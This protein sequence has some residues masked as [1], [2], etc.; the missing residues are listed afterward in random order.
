MSGTD[1]QAPP[2]TVEQIA[3]VCHEANRAWCEANGDRSQR[4]WV[5]AEEW[6]RESAM[7]GVK[8]ALDGQGPEELHESWCQ[9]KLRDGWVYGEAKDAEAKTHP[10]LMPYDLLPPEQRAK[11]HLFLAVVRALSAR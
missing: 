2:A 11:D 5:A 6:Q 1:Q 7:E 3:R 9:S 8:A 4:P 10:C